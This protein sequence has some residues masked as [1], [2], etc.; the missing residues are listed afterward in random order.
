MRIA[1]PGR[2]GPAAVPLR[3]ALP[4]APLTF[5][6]G[7]PPAAGADGAPCLL[8]RAADD[9]NALVVRP[10]P[11]RLGMRGGRILAPLQLGERPTARKAGVTPVPPRPRPPL[12]H[13]SLARPITTGAAPLPH[14][15][16][17]ARGR[18]R[19]PRRGWRGPD[20]HPL[21]K[22]VLPPPACAP[23]GPGSVQIPT[24]LAAPAGAVRRPGALPPGS[25][26]RRGVAAGLYG[27]PVVPRHG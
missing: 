8:Q 1:R 27:R 16:L 25:R 7:P 18:Y 2:A 9:R 15:P 4:P 20:P 10:E 24:R 12:F 23:A 6:G 26:G 3:P 13:A 17:R 5:A 11:R 21:A 19:S 22:D 14:A